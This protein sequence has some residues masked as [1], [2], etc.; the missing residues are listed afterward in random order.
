MSANQGVAPPNYTTDVGRFRLIAADAVWVE[1][2]PP[3][4]GQGDY[5][6]WSDADIQA[7]LDVE[8][9][10][11]RAVGL[12]YATLAAE[13][14]QNAQLIADF[15]LR[16]DARQKADSLRAQSLWFYARAD[17]L[18]AEG[19]EGFQ[20]V[21]TGRR[22]TRAELAETPLIDLDLTEFIV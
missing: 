9:G 6:L 3:V 8:D 22:R 18:D 15:D 11:Y 17:E 12:A 13:A 16:I 21:S 4:S 14:A 1:L 19:A 7:F 10:V 5:T 2:N 20:I